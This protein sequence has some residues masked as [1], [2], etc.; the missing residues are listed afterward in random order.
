MVNQQLLDYINQQ[1]QKG[2]DRTKIRNILI[3]NGWQENDVDE[4]FTSLNL[5]SQTPLSVKAQLQSSP[6]SRI[7]SQATSYSSEPSSGKLKKILIIALLAIIVVFLAGG[8]V[9]AYFNYFQSPEIVVGKMLTKIEDIK[10]LE[11]S[12]EIKMEIDA[13]DL[14]AEYQSSLG[15]SF[16][17]SLENLEEVGDNK[18][19]RLGVSKEKVEFLADFAGAYDI[20]NPEE[21]RSLVSFD[22]ETGMVPGVKIVFGSE[23][24]NIGKVVYVKLSDL[25]TFGF[26]DL[27]SLKNQW[28][29]ID[30]DALSEQFGSG[31]VPGQFAE[32]IDKAQ[33]EEM[34]EKIKTI[35]SQADYSKILKITEKFPNEE[36]E[37]VNSYH[38]GYMI[39]KEEVKNLA[40]T[41]IESSV[42]SM[43]ET[44]TEEE[45]REFEKSFESIGSPEG[46]IWIG[47][48]DLLPHK[49]SFN[50]KIKEI[51]DVD[52]S[53]DISYT[54]F[55][56]NFNNPIIIEAPTQSQTIEELM[57]GLFGGVS[58]DGLDDSFLLPAF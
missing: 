1:I 18:R 27:S 5:P 29:K 22:V 17:A 28:I 25:P 8:G 23:I 7:L 4:A 39:D 53:G 36:I 21:L 46:E 47:K 32:E 15:S 33:T 44:I 11:Y 58:G 38:Y 16:G 37:G 57:G 41:I 24:R 54:L 52:V 42:E 13:G 35:L 40:I 56:K 45:I 2:V 26:F 55:L 6:T 20:G 51:G 50:L 14:I 10:T 48:K 30:T 12:G 49:I 3:A 43:G 34:M 31:V 9:F 19:P